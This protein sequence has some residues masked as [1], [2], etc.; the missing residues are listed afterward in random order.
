MYVWLK[1]L[2]SSSSLISSWGF[3]RLKTIWFSFHWISL[4][5]SQQSHVPIVK[6]IVLFALA[7]FEIHF[8]SSSLAI[9]F[10]Q[11]IGLFALVIFQIHVTSSLL[12]NH[13]VC[14]SV[15][16]NSFKQEFHFGFSPWNLNSLNK[17]FTCDQVLLDF[18]LN[19]LL[20]G[21]KIIRNKNGKDKKSLR[22]Q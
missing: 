17:F 12:A 16:W 11:W 8:T 21:S 13:F 22:W 7:N 9:Q 2:R 4:V 6:W 18:A 20:L 19:N 3:A 5:N 10:H 15:F 1:C 14:T